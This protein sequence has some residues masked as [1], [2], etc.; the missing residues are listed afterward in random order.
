MNRP[1][2]AVDRE[3]F[4]SAQ[5]KLLLTLS[6]E[7]HKHFFLF[8]FLHCD[9]GYLISY[10]IIL[11]SANAYHMYGDLSILWQFRKSHVWYEKPFLQ[12]G[13][14]PKVFCLAST[15]SA[16]CQKV[17]KFFGKFIHHRKVITNKIHVTTQKRMP[18]RNFW[19]IISDW[20]SILFLAA[21]M[22]NDYLLP[23]SDTNLPLHSRQSRNTFAR[24]QVCAV[25][26]M[27]IQR[28]TCSQQILT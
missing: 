15:S 12:L 8:K 21:C 3:S 9:N 17:I 23:H 18:K 24:L 11:L 10:C 4:F 16:L 2:L 28:W 22:S 26:S 1:V 7:K 5:Y 6:R 14:K 27:L 19:L 25:Q 13:V 20:R